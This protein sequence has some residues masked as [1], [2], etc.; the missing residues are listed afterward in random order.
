MTIKVYY[1]FA[2]I[3]HILYEHHKLLVNGTSVTEIHIQARS[4]IYIRVLCYGTR[5]RTCQIL[6]V[7]FTFS[8]RL[9]PMSENN[10]V[11]NSKKYQLNF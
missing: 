9:M 4:I 1:V 6:Y 11:V 5:S 10:I 3:V 7:I 2:H 8:I